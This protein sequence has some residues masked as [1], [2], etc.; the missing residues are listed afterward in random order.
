MATYPGTSGS[1]TI[2]GS[3]D[4][5]TI[6][7]YNPQGGGGGFT[8]QTT[9]VATGIDKPTYIAGDPAN[10][11]RLYILEKTGS[12]KMMSLS[13]GPSSMTTV[14]DLTAQIS[15]VGE[16]GLTGFAF[17][18]QFGQG[19]N[20]KV[21]LTMSNQQ[22]K[23]ELREYSLDNNGVVV[24]SSM[25]LVLKVNDYTEGS[26]F[27]RAGWIGFG[28][29][30]LLYMTTGD[31]EVLASAQDPQDLRGKVLRLKV[32]GGDSYQDDPDK[33]F[34]IPEGNPTQFAGVPGTF[35]K[36]EVYAIGFRNPWRAS[37]DSEGRMFIGD[38]G[39]EQYEEI[40]LLATG[41]SIQ[42]GANYGW[43]HSGP[44]DDGPEPEGPNNPY[45]NP[46]DYYANIRHPTA[47]EEERLGASVTGGYVYNGPVEALKGRYIFA[48][49]GSGR[50]FTLSENEEGN[51][52]RTEVTNL[53]L[54]TVTGRIEGI[55]SFGMDA[56]GNLYV[57]DLGSFQ[58]PS[59]GVI[60]RLTP[61]AVVTDTGDVLNGAA[62]NDTLHGGAGN[63]TLHGGDDDDQLFGEADAD[64][65]YG[66]AGADTLDGG[67]GDDMLYGGAGDDTYILNNGDTIL[68]FADEGIDIVLSKLGNYTL[69]SNLENLTLLDEAFVGI[70]NNL[71]NHI[72][73]NSGTN[74]LYGDDGAD[75]LNGGNGNDLLNGGA[76]HDT[77][78]VNGNGDEII[79]EED[80]GTDT[81]QSSA[82]YSLV[83]LEFIERLTLTGT[84]AIDGTGNGLDN[85]IVGNDAANI[86]D[87]AGGKDA[88]SGG[89]G[90]DTYYVDSEDDS[91][92]E[93]NGKG[94]DTIIV[95]GIAYTLADGVHV[96]NIKAHT[97]N[98]FGDLTGN[99]FA[100]IFRGNKGANLID[101]RGGNDTVVLTGKWADYEITDNKNGSFTLED[102]RQ[103]GDGTDT[104]RNVEIFQFADG[105]VSAENLLN[106]VPTEISLGKGEDAVAENTKNEV[107]F[108]TF[109]VTD[110]DG[111]TH[112]FELT[113]NAG[114]RFAVDPLTGKLRVVDGV[115]LDFEQAA[116]HNITVKVT[117]AAGTGASITRTFTIKVQDVL[118]ENA[119]GSTRSDVILGGVGGDTLS[120]GAGDDTLSAG[121][122]DN[123]LN[124]DD[125][126]DRLIGEAGNDIF[127]GGAGDDTLDAGAGNDRVSGDA[128]NDS[129]T[130]GAGNDVFGGGDGN[131]RLV[132]GL[133]KDTFTG[134]K[135]RD[136]FVFDDKETG[137]SKA[138]ADYITDFKGREGD[139]IDLRAV[140]A[141]TKKSG[142]Q[143]FSF[144]GTKAFSKEGQ[145]RYEKA[146]GTTYVYLNTDS[147]KAAE[148]VI[149]LKGAMDLSKGW[150]VL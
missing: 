125:G 143:N 54:G 141:N 30:G 146:K 1:D 20:R 147:D 3:N 116:Q 69:G 11:D 27:H 55:T 72:I 58:T 106:P 31:G 128:G 113:D 97:E 92:V 4:A 133:G 74:I 2:T 122:G 17:H 96:E 64:E 70:G 139:K 130:G 124:G 5:D 90:D 26:V 50:F 102:K 136:V 19:D 67:A 135:G 32:D 91:I 22:G 42:V 101:G 77:Y 56:Q 126:N 35:A 81:V 149:K 137:S 129:L 29:D 61:Q 131:D 68:E 23:T 57:A 75:T 53:I 48:D 28:P 46:I 87:G 145:V 118:N 88:F 148:A 16:R 132:G 43:G 82:T 40:N 37:F 63:D 15:T 65:L 38:V 127:S 52:Q 34:E 142:D 79:E 134:G 12:L 109:A 94:T 89:G 95:S 112:R 86:L 117:D 21:Y 10:A 51:W 47:P 80:G 13:Q 41:A 18:P 8:I 115:R 84:A 25:K 36:S 100:N 33:N 71:D 76:G 39:Q 111:D 85:E 24:P 83:Y 119:S 105:A 78:I 98:D 66:D 120:G 103:N 108:G 104:I 140:D 9:T 150:F 73:G 14:L 114:G 59:T 62:G 107:V 123:Q 6:Y 110:N 121:A 44:T 45:T 49:F 93:A 60:Y 138:K 99:G 7:G 144:I